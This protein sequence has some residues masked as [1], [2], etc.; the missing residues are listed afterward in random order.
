LGGLFLERNKLWK[1]K[2]VLMTQDPSPKQVE[3]KKGFLAKLIDRLDKK[4]EDKAKKSNCCS[5][6]KSKGGSCC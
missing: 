5:S 4:L 3:K 2:G 1:M 6:G